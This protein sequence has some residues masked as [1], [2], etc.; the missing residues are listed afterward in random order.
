MIIF[1]YFKLCNT[2]IPM[3][4]NYIFDLHIFWMILRKVDLVEANPYKIL[5]YL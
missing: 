1:I 5:F 3:S 4:I 2:M